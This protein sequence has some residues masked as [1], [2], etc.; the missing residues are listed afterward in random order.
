M[1]TEKMLSRKGDL[2]QTYQS[3][4]EEHGVARKVPEEELQEYT[5]HVNYIPHLA[6]LNPRS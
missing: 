1:S 4:I 2:G 3:Q 5:G 6:A